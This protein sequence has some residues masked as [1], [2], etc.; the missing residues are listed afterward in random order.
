MLDVN[1]P[2]RTVPNASHEEAATGIWL[3]IRSGV[4]KG[5]TGGDS[6]DGS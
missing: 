5:Y 6:G 2:Q 3:L 4:R 1:I